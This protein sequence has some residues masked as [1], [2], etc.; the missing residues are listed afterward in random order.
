MLKKRNVLSGRN[1]M[2][3]SVTFF[4]SPFG[5]GGFSDPGVDW[6]RDRFREP[7]SAALEVDSSE[8]FCLGGE[9]LQPVEVR[10][11]AS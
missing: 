7:N 3:Y 10:G 2:L 11:Y 4:N 9:N 8:G 1:M 6:A 5:H